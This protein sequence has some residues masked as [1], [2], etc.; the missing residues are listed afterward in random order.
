MEDVASS[1]AHALVLARKGWQDSFQG[2]GGDRETRLLL[3]ALP[4][5]TERKEAMDKRRALAKS[6]LRL[7]KELA[8]G[9]EERQITHDHTVADLLRCW[10]NH[11]WDKYGPEELEALETETDLGL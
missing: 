2:G 10:R 1:R 4:S 8:G 7:C 3:L 11:I 5:T 6:G 9:N